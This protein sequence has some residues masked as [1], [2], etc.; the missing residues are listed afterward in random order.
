M[1]SGKTDIKDRP[2]SFVALSEMESRST[3]HVEA[4]RNTSLQRAAAGSL[5]KLH[6]VQRERGDWGQYR[7]IGNQPIS[8]ITCPALSNSSVSA[9]VLLNTICSCRLVTLPQVTHINDGGIQSS[10]ALEVVVVKNLAE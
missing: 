6:S 8:I 10:D 7:Q 2:P 1:G 3:G 4:Q 9:K 5:L